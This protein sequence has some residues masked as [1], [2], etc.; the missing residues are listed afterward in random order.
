MKA[1]ITGASSGIGRE[2]C[3]YLSRLGYECILVARRE[4]LL[5]KLVD[6][7]E[8]PSFAEA[9]DITLDGECERLF[10]KY[11]DADLLVNCAGCGV[12]GNF[13]D[14]DLEREKNMLRLNILSLHILTK[15]YLR[16]FVNRGRG[17]IL[18]IGSS[19]GFFSG[20]LFSS[21]YASKAYVLHLS[22][23]ISWENRKKGVSLSVFCPGPVATDFGKADGI[24]DGRGAISAE[25]AAKKAIDG[26]LKGKRIIYPDLK[27]R[28]LVVFSKFAPRRLLLK[29]VEKQQLNKR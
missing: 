10:E 26:A 18:N 25:L 14:T 27:T 3:K 4:E 29:I 17:R 28:A 5:L 20:P 1:L 9:C 8:A 12:F 23:A 7:L 11:S 13:C 16:T 24:T 15:L 2:I 21:Y 22:E 19:A 6:E